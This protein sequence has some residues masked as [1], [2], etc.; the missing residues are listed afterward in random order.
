MEN[1]SITVGDG[2][3][4]RACGEFRLVVE[5]RLKCLMGCR[6]S[7][8]GLS[9]GMASISLTNPERTLCFYEFPVI[10]SKRSWKLSG[11]TGAGDGDFSGQPDSPVWPS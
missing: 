1:I 8:T 9:G 3:I 4:L 11:A 5:L 10:K 6:H 2:R 7:R